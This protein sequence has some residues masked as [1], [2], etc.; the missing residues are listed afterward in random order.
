M[1]VIVRLE[2]CSGTKRGYRAED[3]PVPALALPVGM[4]A[5][6]RT[7]SGSWTPREANVLRLATSSQ[8][9]IG[10]PPSGQVQIE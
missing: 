7:M 8:I 10:D 3:D 9:W 2:A 6:A 5:L 4:V 1:L